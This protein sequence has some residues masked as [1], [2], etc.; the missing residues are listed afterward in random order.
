VFSTIELLLRTGTPTLHTRTVHPHQPASEKEQFRQS[1]EN[2]QVNSARSLPLCSIFHSWWDW[3]GTNVK[4]F[5]KRFIF[6]RMLLKR[7]PDDNNSIRWWAGWVWSE[8]ILPAFLDLSLYIAV[9]EVSSLPTI[10]E[11]VFTTLSSLLLWRWL[12]TPNHTHID[13]ARILSIAELI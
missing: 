4:L 8:I 6:V 10:L 13:N 3:Y 12:M 5:L 7:F 9:R 2:Y 1:V 11:V